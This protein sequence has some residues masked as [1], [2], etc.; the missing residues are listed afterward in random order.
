[1]GEAFLQA[2]PFFLSFWY[3]R[4][5]LATRGAVFFGM[6]AVAGAFNGII[7]YAI[8]KTLAGTGGWL[9]WRWLFLI[10]GVLKSKLGHLS[11]IPANDGCLGVVSVGWGFVIIA[12]LPPLPDQVRWGFNEKEKALAKQR[13]IE[14]YNDPSAKIRPKKV[15]EIFKDRRYYL[16]GKFFDSYSR[17]LEVR[18]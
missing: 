16:Y 8:E 4:E 5:E 10:E 1:M 18:C 12:L 15:L 17:R 3:K 9:A 13:Q 2:G 6:S 14:A 11:P 7:A